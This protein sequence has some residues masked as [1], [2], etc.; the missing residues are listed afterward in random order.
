MNLLQY[1][2][3]AT[4]A[5]VLGALGIRPASLV[6]GRTHCR[7]VPELADRLEVED[8]IDPLVWYPRWADSE[9]LAGWL[10]AATCEALR[11]WKT[12]RRS[13]L[14]QLG[15]PAARWCDAVPNRSPCF[16]DE[17]AFTEVIAL[18]LSLDSTAAG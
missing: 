3:E 13:H 18:R 4:R 2:E 10:A 12:A 6:F 14:R 17:A 5:G 16:A 11:R 7:R 1:I 9:T 15:I 8:W